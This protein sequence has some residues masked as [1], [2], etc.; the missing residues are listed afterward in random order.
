VELYFI[1]VLQFHCIQV[2]QIFAAYF[3]L[4]SLGLSLVLGVYAA[5]VI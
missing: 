5:A 1:L 4:I 2:P 3:P